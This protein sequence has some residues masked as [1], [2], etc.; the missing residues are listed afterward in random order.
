MFFYLFPSDGQQAAMKHIDAYR[1]F[2]EGYQMVPLFQIFRSPM[3][4]I[5]Q[6]NTVVMQFSFGK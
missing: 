2:W 4:V 3:N 5:H 1:Y 6:N